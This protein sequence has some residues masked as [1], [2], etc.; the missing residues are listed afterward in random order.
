[1][2]SIKKIIDKLKKTRNIDVSLVTFATAKVV[3]VSFA[4]KQFKTNGAYGGKPWAFFAGEPEYAAFKE[5]L[6]ASMYPLRWSVGMERIYPALTSRTHP[7]KILINRGKNVFFDI[8]IPHLKDIEAGG[9]NQFEERSPARKVFP[10]GN[11][12]LMRDVLRETNKQFS[13]KV[14]KI[15]KR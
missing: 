1:M 8:R 13:K 9:T 3:V 12:A 7:D 6:G 2:S 10:K 11:G 14:K 4:K 5:A 15:W